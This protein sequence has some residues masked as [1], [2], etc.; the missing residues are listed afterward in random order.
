MSNLKSI[1]LVAVLSTAA[2]PAFAHGGYWHHRGGGPL[3]PIVGLAVGY[4]IGSWWGHGW[5]GPVH[6]VGGH[7]RR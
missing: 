4:S 1:V 6:H 7:F 2:Q 3:Y 5:R